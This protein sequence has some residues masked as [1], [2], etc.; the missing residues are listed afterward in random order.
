MSL[1]GIRVLD[2]SRLLPGP[3]AT[4]VLADMGATVDKIEDNAG[5]D[6]LRHLPPEVGGQ[7]AAFAIL[8]RG[9]R[10]AVLDLKDPVA[11][12]AIR[13]I[14]PRYDVL[15]EQ[16]RP[17]V[18]TRLGLD[19]AELRERFPR[20]VICSLTGYGQTGPL[21]QRAG[22]DLNYL[23][24]AGLL[25][26][27]GPESGPPQPP[28]FQLADVSGGLWSIIA[29]VGALF[30]RERTGK[31]AHLDIAMSE[32]TLPFAVMSIASA[33][34]GAAGAAGGEQLTG[35]IG[36]YATYATR[37]GR[38][39]ALAALEPKFWMKLA[40]SFGI[41]P[42]LGDLL[43]GPHQR[44]L[45]DRLRAIFAEKTLA[46]WVAW[47]ADKDCLIEPVLLPS[48]VENDAHLK[49]RGVFCSVDGP[50]GPVPQMR[51]PVTPRDRPLQVPSEKGADTRTILAEGGIAE[52]VIADLFA[53]GSAK[54]PG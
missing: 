28:G 48:E 37:D 21:A 36:P 30:E 13:A 20:L 12:D 50:S 6:Y 46:E 5:G 27:T 23:A 14:L 22:H 34:A 40:A 41:T 38:A 54:E 4:S 11:R 45:G 44:E 7:N 42:S 9:K 43:P 33:M 26:A 18:L 10:S 19:P 31:G 35:G 3:F 29:I 2:L 39:V 24:R 1:S 49:A 16:F 25:G 8:N 32:G 15:F 53:R 17:G 51:W 47:A 52:G